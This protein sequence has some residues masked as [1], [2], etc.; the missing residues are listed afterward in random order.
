MYRRRLILRRF[1]ALSFGLG[2]YDNGTWVDHAELSERPGLADGPQVA[3]IHAALHCCAAI[4]DA[5]T[6]AI[7]IEVNAPSE[8]TKRLIGKRVASVAR[9]VSS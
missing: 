3:A 5:G 9:S 6:R 7:D 8:G 4:T 1:G 2:Y